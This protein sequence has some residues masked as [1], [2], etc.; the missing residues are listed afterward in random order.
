MYWSKRQ[1][2]TVNFVKNFILMNLA[3]EASLGI[4]LCVSECVLAT[5][6]GK[7]PQ[8]EKH[9]LS[10]GSPWILF[11]SSFTP[12]KSAICTVPLGCVQFHPEA[13]PGATK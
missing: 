5:Q 1:K 7:N 6:T 11:P 10:M 13:F 9:G 12:A 4:F 3:N 8:L 2:Q